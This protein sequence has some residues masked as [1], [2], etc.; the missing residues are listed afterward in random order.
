MIFEYKAR[1]LM[2]RVQY[3][4]WLVTLKDN[5]GKPFIFSSMARVVLGYG[6]IKNTSF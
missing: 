1:P 5:V 4:T 3:V 6:C 2:A